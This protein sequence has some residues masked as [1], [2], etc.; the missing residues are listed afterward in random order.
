MIIGISFFGIQLLPN[1][2]FG[3]GNVFLICAL[4]S[5]VA[6]DR[7]PF[8][9][10]PKVAAEGQTT[11]RNMFMLL[12]LP[13]FA[14]PHYFLFDFPIVISVIAALTITAGVIALR[15]MKSISWS[16]VKDA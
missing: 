12:A 1:L 7:L 2:V 14:L 15:Y 5:W 8:S 6:M 16:Y 3:L 4:Y 9:L 10:S 13:F 11:F